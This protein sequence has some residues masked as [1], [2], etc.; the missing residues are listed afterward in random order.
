M[1]VISHVDMYNQTIPQ[2]NIFHAVQYFAKNIGINDFSYNDIMNPGKYLFLSSEFVF[3]DLLNFEHLYYLTDPKR[4]VNHFTAMMQFLEYCDGA[5]HK[6]SPSIEQLVAQQK[7]KGE[8]LTKIETLKRD[9]N[10][11]ATNRV[12]RA[13]RMKE[14]CVTSSCTQCD[15]KSCIFLNSYICNSWKEQSKKKNRN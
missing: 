5:V 15:K 13:E 2:L 12:K 7:K 9:I 14:V 6:I 1:T 4:T 8:L 10:Q 3:T 11:R